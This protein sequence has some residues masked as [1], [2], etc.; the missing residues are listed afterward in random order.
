MM[1]QNPRQ[2][3]IVALVPMRHESERVPGKNYRDMAGSP[4]YAYILRSLEKVE[5]IA[6]IVVDTDSEII[7]AGISKDF[8]AVRLIERPA[9]LR[10]GEIPMNDILLH[11]SSVV[12]ADFYLQSHSTNPLLE[13]ASIRRAIET[14]LAA[15]PEND[16]L[17]S[18]TELHTRLYD[19]A[20]QAINHDPNELLRTQDLP[21]IYEENSCIYIFDRATL[22]TRGHRI[23]ERP[24]MFSIP[25]EQALDIDEE[26]D[27]QMA[28]NIILQRRKT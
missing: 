25:A 20:G 6:E 2:K 14:F 9:H 15:H 13:T 17:F 8:P 24:I 16:S 19:Q 18:V 27:F 26:N 1:A 5:E 4:L 11:D 23:G 21:P 12:E 28:E 22:K 7:R 3:R 10:E